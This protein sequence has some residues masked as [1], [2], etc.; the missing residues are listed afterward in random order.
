MGGSSSDHN[1]RSRASRRVV[2]A[3]LVAGA[4]LAVG[5]FAFAYR[6]THPRR[7][8]VGADERAEGLPI[9]DVVF[10]SRDGVRLSGWFIPAERPLGGVVLCHGF[11]SNRTE[12]LPVAR[13][14]RD[15]R[16]SLFLFDFRALGRSE[17]NLCTIGSHEVRD[18]LGAVD[19]VSRRPEMEG[20]NLGVYGNSM[21]GAVAIMAAANDS[22]IAAVAAHGAYATLERAI[23]Q[24][25]RMALGPLGPA[26]HKPAIWWGRRLWM[27]RHPREVSPAGV[28]S[29][30]APRPVLILHGKHDHTIRMDDADT[31]M[32]AAGEPKEMVVLP[33]SWHIWVHPSDRSL[34]ERSITRFFSRSLASAE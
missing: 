6:A 27:D 29:Q 28:I 14:L 33:R 2:P 13:L 10:A 20:L 23:A 21:G 22:R 25:C 12:M 15:A 16:M 3:A 24:R 34:Y 1:A 19:F 17:G 32:D 7:K 5:S 9:E 31:L 30:I 8:A 11:P 4:A 18:L 26:M